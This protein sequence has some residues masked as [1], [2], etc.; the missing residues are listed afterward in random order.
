MMSRLQQTY[1]AGCCLA[2]TKHCEH[3]MTING[4]KVAASREYDRVLRVEH[5]GSRWRTEHVVVEEPLEIRIVYGPLQERREKA[6]SVTM[7]T[8]GHDVELAT[9]FLLTEG[10]VRDGNDIDTAESAAVA[11]QFPIPSRVNSVRVVLSPDVEV[12]QPTLERNFYTTSSCGICGKASLLALQT[13]CPPRRENNFIMDA[14][15]IR[16]LPEKLRAHQG[17]FARTGGLHGAA[18]VR[19]SGELYRLREDVGRHNAVDKLIGAAAIADELPL[20]QSALV[21]SGRVSFELMQKAVMAGIPAVIAIGAPSTLA[22]E[23]AQTFD[24]TLV[25]FL[26]EDHFNVYNGASRVS[27]MNA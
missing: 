18:L 19:P 4:N 27:S 17:V 16:T 2:H 20:R 22:I 21:L 12:N 7:R 26:R 13:V 8:P 23:V 24:V 14:E 3:A 10:V 1:R 5:T 25:A 15:V 6:I 11:G 9:G